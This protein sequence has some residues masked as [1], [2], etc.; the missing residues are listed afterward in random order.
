[1]THNFTKLNQENENKLILQD[2]MQ[3]TACGLQ[4]DAY[5]LSCNPIISQSC[6]PVIH[7]S[8]CSWRLLLAN[9]FLLLAMMLG[10]GDVWGQKT[11]FID[12][13]KGTEGNVTKT[14]EGNYTWTVPAGV[15]VFRVHGI[16]GGGGGGGAH[17]YAYAKATANCSFTPS[18]G[19]GHCDSQAEAGAF[20]FAGGSGGGGGAYDVV[21]ITNPS[22]S[23]NLYIGKG[24]TANN[25]VNGGS[26]A[27]DGEATWFGTNLLR[28]NGGTR[29]FYHFQ[30]CSKSE[31]NNTQE[32][33]GDLCYSMLSDPSNGGGKNNSHDASVKGNNGSKGTYRHS[34]STYSVIGGQ[35]GSAPSIS[36]YSYS[37]TGGAG[38]TESRGA[39]DGHNDTHTATSGYKYGGGGGGGAALARKFVSAN[40]SAT[41]AFG[42]GNNSDSDSKEGYNEGYGNG[43]DGYN[44]CVWIEYITASASVTQHTCS[45]GNDGKIY[46]P[47]SLSH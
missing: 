47:R 2:N 38:R 14:S 15:T 20:A 44:G 16:G 21:T 36:G 24:G 12:R 18:W 22:A 43:G 40:A 32:S 6:A 41:M 19:A 11:D 1:M 4:P 27:S 45:N 35:G 39:S 3:H 33:G 30:N 26:D 10:I 29:G 5:G 9:C 8:S 37:G 28:A 42:I 25:D 17:A 46:L 23:Y 34:G 13:T 31:N 7:K